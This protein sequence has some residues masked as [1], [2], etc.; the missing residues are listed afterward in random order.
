MLLA[1]AYKRSNQTTRRWHS[2]RSIDRWTYIILCH[3]V[4][5]LVPAHVPAHIW[6]LEGDASSCQDFAKS[7]GGCLDVMHPGSLWQCV[8]AG[9]QQLAL[10]DLL[11]G[12]APICQ[13]PVRQELGH[14][15]VHSLQHS[16]INLHVPS[17][18]NIHHT[19]RSAEQDTAEQAPRE[20]LKQLARLGTCL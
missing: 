14:A 6:I 13:Q 19:I 18:R 2:S 10:C 4:S 1:E 7:C 9:R 17:S 16:R 20:A 11:R 3:I 8:Q 12:M 15:A 5:S